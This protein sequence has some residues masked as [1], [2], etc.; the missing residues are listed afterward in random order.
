MTCKK[1]VAHLEADACAFSPVPGE[2]YPALATFLSLAAKDLCPCVSNA[3]NNHAFSESRFERLEAKQEALVTSL[4]KDRCDATKCG[5]KCCS[6]L[7]AQFGNVAV[8][9]HC[10]EG[11][12]KNKN[13]CQI[14]IDMQAEEEQMRKGHVHL[15]DLDPKLRMWALLTFLPRKRI[16]MLGHLCVCTKQCQNRKED[17]LP[18][19][20]T[21]QKLQVR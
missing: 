12:A 18:V 8:E 16:S 1:L 20:Q 10:T 2:F 13:V 19:R 9:N 11:F 14:F 3:M 5:C 21:L 4:S 7:K 15:S 6:Q 17:L